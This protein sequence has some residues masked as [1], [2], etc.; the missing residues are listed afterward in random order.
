MGLGRLSREDLWD[1]DVE[2]Y[3]AECYGPISMDYTEYD[4]VRMFIGYGVGTINS[5][6]L[7]LGYSNRKTRRI[8]NQLMRQ[9]IV[10]YQSGRYQ[11]KDVLL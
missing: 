4:R 11:L 3:K 2:Q 10:E 7:L 9:G 6:G 1:L 5:I 8:V